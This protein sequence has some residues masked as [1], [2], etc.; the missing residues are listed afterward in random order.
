MLREKLATPI[1]GATAEWAREELAE[2]TEVAEPAGEASESE[3]SAGE[4]IFNPAREELSIEKR[5]DPFSRP[6]P[7]FGDM[8]VDSESVPPRIVSGPMKPAAAVAWS[9]QGPGFGAATGLDPGRWTEHS[10]RPTAVDAGVVRASANRGVVVTASATT[11][12]AAPNDEATV[13]WPR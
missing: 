11:E 1:G 4:A 5:V 2:S 9:D 6:V 7:D 13:V 8:I 10:A 3:L 12:A